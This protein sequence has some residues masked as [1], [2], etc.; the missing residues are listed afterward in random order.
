MYEQN[1]SGVKAAP[2]YVERRVTGTTPSTGLSS[3]TQ[4]MPNG[5]VLIFDSEGSMRRILAT[6]GL[7]VWAAS[8]IA[9]G[10]NLL[11]L[12][13]SL[14]PVLE[15]QSTVGFTKDDLLKAGRCHG[16]IEGTIKTINLMDKVHEK[17]PS[18][19]I[20]TNVSPLQ[21]AKIVVKFVEDNPKL[22]HQS[23]TGLIATAAFENY[24]CE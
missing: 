2:N 4:M 5:H 19:C 22:L 15:Q 13:R 24:L 17:Q 9:D 7:T 6:V 3:P 1:Y 12:C 14:I 16:L 23:E 20:P 11:Q 18:I 21:L 10:N 8:A